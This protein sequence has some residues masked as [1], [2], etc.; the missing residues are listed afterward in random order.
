MNKNL[1]LF[2]L[3]LTLLDIDSDYTWGEFIVK[4]GL[5]DIENYRQK[6]KYF[7]EQYKK[8]T[9]DAVEYNEFVASFLTTLPLDKLHQLREEFIETEIKPCSCDCSIICCQ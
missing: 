5:V 9:L 4:K 7:H 1:A 8:G 6:N 2:D 3:D